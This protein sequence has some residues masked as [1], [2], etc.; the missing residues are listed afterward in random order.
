MAV[1]K[2]TTKKAAKKTKRKTAKKPVKKS[3]TSSKESTDIIEKKVLA[4]KTKKKV[5]FAGFW[6]R[7]IAFIIDGILLGVIGLFVNL[8]SSNFSSVSTGVNLLVG[9]LYFSLLE[10]SSWQGSVGKKILNLK[11]VGRK[12]NRIS[13]LRA[14]GRYFS[15]I[16]S[17]AIF[18]IGFIMI[19]FTKRKQGLHDMIAETLVVQNN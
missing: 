10:S 9:W 1:K 13:F 6:L 11:V 16:I 8:G 3:L 7:L 2:K 15:K 19:A 5:K 4:A 12:G 14:T 17:A 18:M